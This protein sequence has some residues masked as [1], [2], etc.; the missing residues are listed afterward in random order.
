MNAE[1]PKDLEIYHPGGRKTEKNNRSYHRCTSLV[2]EKNGSISNFHSTEQTH[3]C[4]SNRRAADAV[5]LGV[6]S[7]LLVPFFVSDL[8]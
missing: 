5:M 1:Y 3:A 6:F 2:G 7:M 8:H 4:Y